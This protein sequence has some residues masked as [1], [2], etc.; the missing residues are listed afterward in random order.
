MPSMTASEVKC[1][2]TVE[3][4]ADFPF[5][6]REQILQL[7]ALRGPCQSCRAALVLFEDG[8]C[9]SAPAG[10]ADQALLFVLAGFSGFILECL[11]DADGADIG[12]HLLLGAALADPVACGDGVVLLRALPDRG[13]RGA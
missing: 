13:R 6:G 4:R 2:L 9:K 11:E 3:A 8:L 7:R 12:A 1:A 10:I 5:P